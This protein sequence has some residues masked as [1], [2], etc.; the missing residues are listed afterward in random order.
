MFLR[1]WFIRADKQDHDLNENSEKR[2]EFPDLL[3]FEAVPELA[4]S[5][6]Q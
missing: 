2:P 1:L 6:M 4:F 5:G 3:I